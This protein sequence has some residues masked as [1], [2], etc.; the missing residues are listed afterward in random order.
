MPD[1]TDLLDKIETQSSIFDKAAPDLR[2]QINQAIVDHSPPTYRGIYEKFRL[3]DLGISFHALYRYARRLRLHA[4]TLDLAEL[5][6]PEGAD[7]A[8]TLPQLLAYR[9]MEAAIDED[10]SPATLHR[11][12]HSWRITADTRFALGRHAAE[13]ENLRK[14]AIAKEND[15]FL[16][17]TRQIIKLQNNE[18]R[19]RAAAIQNLSAQPDDPTP[20]GFPA[21][22]A[23][24]PGATAQ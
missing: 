17:M 18:A 15:E 10:A 6:L 4:A 20:P 16:A 11:L 5:V 2:R 23:P 21:D 7:P 24:A 3:A 9:L 22:D 1:K 13:F 19:A 12:A 14:K 8:D